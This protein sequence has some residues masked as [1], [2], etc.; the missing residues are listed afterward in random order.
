[1]IFLIIATII[2]LGALIAALIVRF[3]HPKA[4]QSPINVITAWTPLNLP[5]WDGSKLKLQL[6][7]N[8]KN[9]LGTNGKYTYGM[10]ENVPIAHANVYTG[11]YNSEHKY[12]QFMTSNK[13][14]F[15][16]NTAPLMEN[17]LGNWAPDGVKNVHPVVFI[18]KDGKLALAT[19]GSDG[20]I[21]QDGWVQS[22]AQYLFQW[23]TTAPKTPVQLVQVLT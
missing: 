5:K 7:S 23:T 19:T 20:S 21:V 4:T 8:P 16:Y 2:S 9:G 11:V 18:V 10:L 15:C 22:W 14:I 13:E 17:T 1:M 6:V 12:L 3:K